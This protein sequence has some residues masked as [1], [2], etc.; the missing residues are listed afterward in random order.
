MKTKNTT[1]SL[2]PRAVDATVPVSVRVN[3]SLADRLAALRDRAASQGLVLDTPRAISEALEKFARVAERDLATVSK[4][5][6]EK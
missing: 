3:R 1:K 4:A 2:R 5:A 6:A